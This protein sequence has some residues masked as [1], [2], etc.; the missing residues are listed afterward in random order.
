MT[1][2]IARI[3][4]A[5]QQGTIGCEAAHRLA[6]ELGLTPQALGQLV[7]DQTELRFD[8]CQLGLFGYGRK[9]TEAYRIVQP[10]GHCPAEIV[11]AIQAQTVEGRVSCN[12]LW[13]IAAEFR[14]PRLGIANIAEAL[15][16]KV[17][18]CQLG[19]F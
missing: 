10:A 6:A 3:T 12:A 1:I 9:G 2:T 17:K 7:N 5:S 4:Q 16:L 18:P 8:R 11:A 19:C 14:Y 15:G 13:A